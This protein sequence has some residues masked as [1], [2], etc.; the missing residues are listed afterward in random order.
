MSNFDMGAFLD[1][2]ANSAAQTYQRKQEQR[3]QREW[4]LKLRDID[5]KARIKLAETKS[6]LKAQEASDEHDRKKQEKIDIDEADRITQ[7]QATAFMA[8]TI[9]RTKPQPFMQPMISNPPFMQP[10]DN[11]I[12]NPPFMQSNPLAPMMGVNKP[13]MDTFDAA[14]AILGN[15]DLSAA[16][17]K[18]GVNAVMD[19]PGVH[20]LDTGTEIKSVPNVAGQTIQKPPSG[21]AVKPHGSPWPDANGKLMQTYTDGTYKAVGKAPVKTDTKKPGKQLTRVEVSEEIAAAEKKMAD[22]DVEVAMSERD[23]IDHWVARNHEPITTYTEQIPWRS[24]RTTDRRLKDFPQEWKGT[25]RAFVRKMNKAASQEQHEEA[26]TYLAAQAAEKSGYDENEFF[27]FLYAW[28][29]WNTR[30][31]A[32]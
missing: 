10:M 23:K 13:E 21:G 17:Q 24:D 28:V 18:F 16:Q 14:Q 11:Q 27:H 19:K 9:E 2:M 8:E 20:W 1:N 15:Q 12:S 31:R 30:K 22:S 29:R 6:K 5:Q 7:E 4:D 3:A 32:K 25:A 26:I